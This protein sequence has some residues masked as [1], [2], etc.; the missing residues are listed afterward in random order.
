MPGCEE[1]EQTACWLC[2]A[3]TTRGAKVDRWQGAN[4]T[5][6]NKARAASATHVCCEWR[7]SGWCAGAEWAG[8]SGSGGITAGA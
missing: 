5:D 2:A 7:L 4:F 3:E 6:Q 8:P 1:V